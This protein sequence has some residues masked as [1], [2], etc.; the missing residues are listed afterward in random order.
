MRMVEVEVVEV[1]G[2]ERVAEFRGQQAFLDALAATLAALLMLA[3][4]KPSR[5]R[6]AMTLACETRCCHVLFDAAADFCRAFLAFTFLFSFPYGI[7][8]ACLVVDGSVLAR[9]LAMC[10]GA[11]IIIINVAHVEQS[12]LGRLQS[13]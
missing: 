12:A 11:P 9:V 8:V 1:A 4:F 7:E 3:A 5:E 2:R 13:A 10:E 6:V